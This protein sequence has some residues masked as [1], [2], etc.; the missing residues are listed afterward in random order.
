M[1]VYS[2]RLLLKLHLLLFQNYISQFHEHWFT[3]F[4]A[5]LRLMLLFLL[6][7]I[8]RKG[9]W[10]GSLEFAVESGPII[11]LSYFIIGAN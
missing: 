10:S 9:M 6:Q 5:F 8:S 4:S 3:Y 11:V 7:R 2:S 1:Y